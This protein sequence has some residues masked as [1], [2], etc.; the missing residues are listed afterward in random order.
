MAVALATSFEDMLR[1]PQKEENEREGLTTR[2]SHAQSHWRI[3]WRG[4]Q[5]NKRVPPVCP[6]SFTPNHKSV[7]VRGVSKNE[8]VVHSRRS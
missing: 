8:G 2:K 4:E 5:A 6:S 7:R 3:L 1:C